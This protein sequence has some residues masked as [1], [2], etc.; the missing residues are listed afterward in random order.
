RPEFALVDTVLDL[1][2]NMAIVGLEDPKV[3]LQT[4]YDE[5]EK[6]TERLGRDNQILIYRTMMGMD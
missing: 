4:V 6:I 1:H 2:V 3:A 5:W